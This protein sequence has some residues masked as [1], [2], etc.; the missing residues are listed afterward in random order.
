MSRAPSDLFTRRSDFVEMLN[1][2]AIPNLSR[3]RV[4]VG[5][6]KKVGRRKKKEREGERERIL[7][8][9]E[10]S[11]FSTDGRRIIKR[12]RAGCRTD[13]IIVVAL[14]RSARAREGDGGW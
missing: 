9:R 8:S 5:G 14:P 4:E 10:K 1:A 3:R 12:S 11:R 7:Y 6:E 13:V 2:D